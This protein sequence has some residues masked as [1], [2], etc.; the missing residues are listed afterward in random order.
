MK[1]PFWLHFGLEVPTGAT[2]AD[3]PKY[4][5]ELPSAGNSNR[6]ARAD[7]SHQLQEAA[8]TPG[9]QVEVL[10]KLQSSG[11]YVQG[12]SD[13]PS[14]TVGGGVATLTPVADSFYVQAGE[15]IEDD[16]AQSIPVARIGSA[17]ISWLML[18]DLGVLVHI[19]D[20]LAQSKD[21]I[22]L[23]KLFWDRHTNSVRDVEVLVP[24]LG[25][26]NRDKVELKSWAHREFLRHA[27]LSHDLTGFTPQ[28]RLATR[29]VFD[30]DT[31]SIT[32][33]VLDPANA[34]VYWR[35]QEIQLH[36]QT[37][38]L[39]FAEFDN[40]YLIL[41]PSTGTLVKGGYTPGYDSLLV[42]Y[43]IWNGPEGYFVVEGDERHLAQR[44][45]NW[46]RSQHL[47]WG[48]D[49]RAGAGISFELN[50]DNTWITVGTPI[51]IA[52]EDL[53]HTINHSD[54]P[55]GPYEQQLELQTRLPVVVLGGS[56]REALRQMPATAEGWLGDPSSEVILYNHQD[57]N[58]LEWVL[59]EVPDL[60]FVSYWFVL[61]TCQR[62][63]VKLIAG[64]DV[65]D[66]MQEA[67]EEILMDYGLRV[68]ELHL[69]YH[70]VLQR[71]SSIGTGRQIRI[72]S[73]DRISKGIIQRAAAFSVDSHNSLVGRS[74]P[75]AHPA[76]AITTT[77]LPKLEYVAG[78]LQGLVET[79]D[80]FAQLPIASEAQAKE[81]TH[82]ASGMTPYLVAQNF[83]ERLLQVL[84]QNPDKAMSQKA[85]TDLLVTKE[86]TAGDNTTGIGTISREG[87]WGLGPYAEGQATLDL[88]LPGGNGFK[89]VHLT[90]ADGVKLPGT[91]GDTD[92]TSVLMASSLNY[93]W[94]LLANDTGLYYAEGH[95]PT[96]VPSFSR[97][98]QAG[99]TWNDL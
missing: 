79:L 87:A 67:K 12:Y 23:A 72:V 57:L 50:Q 98:V 83:A 38:M 90:G 65:F 28:A 25:L 94:Y 41:D 63:P 88:S 85:I 93:V 44:D 32:L 43:Y 15:L 77:D 36:T 78:N 47:D 5:T 4:N 46:H 7:H 34:I 51:R 29:V 19:E 95:S 56:D 61:T 1:I 81:G 53:E 58:T 40:E 86:K 54:T 66:T 84:G 80:K 11:G 27:M 21:W 33:E 2:E 9:F 26:N 89:V 8:D 20:A 17:D 6:F 31:P 99:T 14:L 71:D 97:L 82:K 48:L 62:Q 30:K 64:R 69:M 10:R 74:D 70:F 39:D 37:L 42:A 49:W 22:V 73:V 60:K 18:N 76:G 91:E 92:R 24:S 68:A 35:G 16:S 3:L 13:L 55:S 52:D 59:S 45:T 75:D 96:G